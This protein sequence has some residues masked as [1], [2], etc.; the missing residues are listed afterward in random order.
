MLKKIEEMKG[1][2]AAWHFC[3]ANP[4]TND[5]KEVVSKSLV[6]FCEQWTSHGDKVYSSFIIHS[7]FVLVIAEQEDSIGGC[8]KDGLFRTMKDLGARLDMDFFDRMS[9][10]VEIH[11]VE[12]ICSFSEIKTMLQSG[13]IKDLKIWDTSLQWIHSTKELGYKSPQATWFKKYLAIPV[14]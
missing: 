4:L 8:S 14:E 6:T 2:M 12:K 10:P 3:F 11:G 13:D 9:V 5:Q 7:N 1:S